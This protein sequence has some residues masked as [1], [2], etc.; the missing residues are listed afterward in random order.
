M[1][2]SVNGVQDH[3][4]WFLHLFVSDE[5]HE[6]GSVKSLPKRRGSLMGILHT[7]YETLLCCNSS[8]G[9]SLG[10]IVSRSCAEIIF[11]VQI[12]FEQ[13]KTSCDFQPVNMKEKR[14]CM[15]FLVLSRQVRVNIHIPEVMFELLSRNSISVSVFTL[16]PRRGLK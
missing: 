7:F 13:I 5:E 16:C 8:V 6:H 12:I 15:F 3:F 10:S 1:K 4:K 11:K 14:S 2:L 9:V